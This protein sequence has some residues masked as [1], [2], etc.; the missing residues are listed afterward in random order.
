MT[1]LFLFLCAKFAITVPYL[2][3]AAYSSSAFRPHTLTESEL[4]SKG[5]SPEP[6]NS[7]Q[8][9]E[10]IPLSKVLRSQAAAPPAYLLGLAC[11]PIFTAVY[12]TATR[13]T[14]YR[15]HGFDL[16]FGSL[17]GFFTA[18][19]SFRW[20]HAP[21]NRGAGWAWGP[22]T[23]ERAFAI[24]VGMHGYAGDDHSK[25]SDEVVLDLE[26]GEEGIPRA[27]GTETTN[28]EGSSYVNSEPHAR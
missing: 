28:G 14:D 1:Y 26:T 8:P 5:A 23:P 6:L 11:V 13:F 27:P 25:K 15:H 10:T 21:I 16:I 19:G 24:G 2:L 17:I 18:Y 7:R 9:S 12:I 20:Y 4:N 3:P 22:R